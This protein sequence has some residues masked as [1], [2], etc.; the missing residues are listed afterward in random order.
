[1]TIMLML[2]VAATAITAIVIEVA[3]VIV[4]GIDIG[5]LRALSCVSIYP[6]TPRQKGLFTRLSVSTVVD[7][8][9]D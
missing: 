6:L 9:V 3:I 1:M 7:V 8:H 5:L 4:V 2:V